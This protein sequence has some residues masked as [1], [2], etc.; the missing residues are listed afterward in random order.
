MLEH[1]N[2]N[3]I[4]NTIAMLRPERDGVFLVV[5]GS[6]DQYTVKRH[7]DDDA[8]TVLC[9]LGGK[10]DLLSASAKVDQHGTPQVYFLIDSDY[11]KFIPPEAEYGK[12]VI[13][14]DGHDL[15]MDLVLI[16]RSIIHRVIDSH[17]RGHSRGGESIDAADVLTKAIDL[18]LP[19]GVLRM[20]SVEN[21]WGLNLRDYPFGR[22]KSTPPDLAEI[23]EIAVERSAPVADEASILPALTYAMTSYRTHATAIVGDH[24]CFSAIARVMCD[25]GFKKAGADHLSSSFLAAVGCNSLNRTSWF[26]SMSDRIAADTGGSCFICPCDVA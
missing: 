18:A 21:G 4:F 7:V 1:L 12:T 8:V 16:D 15:V 19:V 3:T 23:V 22:L 17:T 26:T 2:A 20:L 10:P 6:D 11:D 14:S 24:D 25:R 5:E 13:A 9:G